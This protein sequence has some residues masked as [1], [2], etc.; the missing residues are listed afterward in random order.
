MKNYDSDTPDSK[1]LFAED[2]LRNTK[3]GRSSFQNF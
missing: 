1:Y 2:L 3:D